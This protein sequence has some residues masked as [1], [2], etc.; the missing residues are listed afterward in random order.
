MI[1]T[2]RAKHLSVLF[3][4]MM[5]FTACGSE[6]MDDYATNQGYEVVS[7]ETGEQSGIPKEEIKVGVL[8]I[9]DPAEGSECRKIWDL[10]MI[11]LFERL[12]SMTLMKRQSQR[13]FR[14]V[15]MKAVILF[16]PQAGD[17]CSQRQIWRRN[18]RRSIFPMEPDI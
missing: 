15:W 6:A 2:K 1:K 4:C 13:L 12:M 11:R 7:T 17:I 14:N 8:H 10:P 9:T 3:S 16:L 5:L 18:I